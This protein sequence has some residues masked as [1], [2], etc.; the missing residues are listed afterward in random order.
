MH[1]HVRDRRAE[2]APRPSRVT[3]ETTHH[4]R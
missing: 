4:F 2:I 3:C 1:R